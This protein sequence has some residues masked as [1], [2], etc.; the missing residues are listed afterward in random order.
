LTAAELPGYFVRESESGD[1]TEDAE[2]V[3][4]VCGNTEEMLRDMLG[5]CGLEKS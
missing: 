3:E 1:S 5:E 2:H 4:A